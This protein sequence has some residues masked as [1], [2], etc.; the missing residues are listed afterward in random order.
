[1]CFL[2][3]RSNC[4]ARSQIL[5]SAGLFVEQGDEGFIWGM[6]LEVRGLGC[7]WLL[8]HLE[9][10]LCPCPSSF[11]SVQLVDWGWKVG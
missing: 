9:E 10:D 5:Y 4:E 3:K 8:V 7:S 11:G 2:I 1:M 6:E